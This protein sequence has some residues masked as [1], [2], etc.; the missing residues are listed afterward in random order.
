MRKITFLLLNVFFVLS[1]A[2]AADYENLY[3]VGNGCD[4]GWSPNDALEMT[5][6]DDGTFTWIGDLTASGDQRFKFLV[7]RGD[8]HPS[9]TCR[10]DVEGHLR[11]ES[12]V[13]YDLYE[14]PDDSTG[15]DNAFQVPGSGEYRI[16]IDLTTMKIVITKTGN[17]EEPTPDLTQLYINGSALSA[18]GEWDYDN[19]SEMT[20]T[21]EGVFTW[22][23]DLYNAE[24]GKNEFKFKNVANSWDKTFCSTQEDIT[25][26]TGEF[27]LN[28]RPYES[29]PD[30]HK[31]KVTI[32]GCYTITA[33][34]NTMKMTVATDNSGIGNL[35]MPNQIQISGNAV[36]ILNSGN[37]I[38]SAALY[39]ITGK[40]LNAVSNMNGTVVLAENL[41]NG[42]YIVKMDYNGKKSVQK[43]MIK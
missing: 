25:I 8:W 29:S 24:E 12:G 6:E 16:V 40:C 18:D 38:Q 11:I 31:F 42:I 2:S 19:P 23:G 41:T 43:I 13:E 9:I 36:T 39:D 7:S 22:T 33:N 21:A 28:F 3:V 34:L 4:A 26:T 14:R 20:M 10:L 5:K 17:T 1:L 37:A 32:A 35:N 15:Y 30:D 27:D